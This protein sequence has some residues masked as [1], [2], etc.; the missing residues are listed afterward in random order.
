MSEHISVILDKVLER[1]D[2]AEPLESILADYPTQRDELVSLLAVVRELS[3]LRQVPLP[4]EPEAGLAAFLEEA[5][6]LAPGATSR[7]GRWRWLD[8][9][10]V[11]LRSI[12]YS[13][14]WVAARAATFLVLLFVLV[15]GALS[16]SANSLP[17][18][19]LY[20]VKLAS[21]EA[22]LSLT[23]SQ[24]ARAEYHLQRAQN[25]AE[26]LQRLVRAGRPVDERTLARLEGALEASLLA[27][28]SAD[29][30]Q[31][32]R[33]LFAIE[34]VSAK[35][36]ALLE[37]AQ[38]TAVNSRTRQL[39][40]QARADLIQA[41]SLAHV[42]RANVYTFRLNASL[43]ALQLGAAPSLLETEA[44]P[45]TLSPTPTLYQVDETR[46]C[47]P[48][49][50]S[51]ARPTATSTARPTGTH[52][53]TTWPSDTPAPSLTP[54]TTRTLEPPTDT[55]TIVPPTA[56]ATLAPTAPP[57]NTPQPPEPTSTPQ[58]PE[59]TSTPQPP[60]PTG[61]PQPPEPTGTHQPPG[62]TN[63]PQPPGQDK[64]PK[65]T[66]TPKP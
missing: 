25:R 43:G 3:P 7:R 36:A 39:L 60:E 35:Q 51:T 32:P 15:S 65:P 34:Q 59:P 57:T 45:A 13:R 2:S 50:T 14:T 46:T 6:A 52:T 29:Q 4:S 27:A 37:L 56:T 63:T 62:L 16:L 31:I 66:K 48:T 30:G 20:P 44:L 19:W 17:G 61:T 33:L 11:A 42:G 41:Q 58:P 21:E 53:P 28:A 40:G 9:R 23:V 49:A 22:R 64:T 47:T 38:A 10:L 12:S 55:A 8:E 24:S 18:D 54:T 26:E 1:L 5:R